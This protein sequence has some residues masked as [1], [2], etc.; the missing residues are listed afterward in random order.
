[1]NFLCWNSSEKVANLTKLVKPQSTFLTHLL[2]HQSINKL[3][4]L[5]N[6]IHNLIEL[7]IVANN[8]V[9]S[10]LHREILQNLDETVIALSFVTFTKQGFQVVIRDLDFLLVDE[11]DGFQN[12]VVSQVVAE[13]E[14]LSC[15][16]EVWFPKKLAKVGM[17]SLTC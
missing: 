16:A 9:P 13:D 17:G 15:S 5:H 8:V 4:L 6:I 12:F 1:M 14:V 3:L 10:F 7:L 2:V 11:L